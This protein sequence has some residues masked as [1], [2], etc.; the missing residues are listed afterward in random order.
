MSLRGVLLWIIGVVL[1]T[2]GLVIY[3]V[4]L[5][6]APVPSAAAVSS[7]LPEQATQSVPQSE[8]AKVTGSAPKIGRAH[9]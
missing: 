8:S 6:R 9:V 1:M 7:L 5:A 4:S 2:V 3:R